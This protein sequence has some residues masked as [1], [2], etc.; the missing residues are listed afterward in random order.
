MYEVTYSFNERFVDISW[1]KMSQLTVSTN[2]VCLVNIPWDITTEVLSRLPVK[3]LMRFKCVS[4]S[5]YDLISNDT[6]FQKKHLYHRSSLKILVPQRET[7][8]V[9]A[10]SC[11][12]SSLN[13]GDNMIHELQ[14][15]IGIGGPMYTNGRFHTSCDGLFCIRV[16]GGGVIIWNP[17]TRQVRECPG[18]DLVVHSLNP[19][20]VVYSLAHDSRSDVYKLL[21][22]FKCSHFHPYRLCFYSS[23]MATWRDVE[24]SSCDYVRYDVNPTIVNGAF[25]WL[26]CHDEHFKT[27]DVVV[28]LDISD[29]TYG[30]FAMPRT[31][32]DAK[33]YPMLCALKGKL[34]LFTSQDTSSLNYEIWVMNEYGVVDSMS[35]MASIS[36]SKPPR[37][38]YGP[39]PYCRPLHM[40]EDGTIVIFRCGK[41]SLY[42]DGRFLCDTSVGASCDFALSHLYLESLIS[43]HII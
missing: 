43:P 14:L 12:T 21:G 38:F 34:C 11:S 37:N 8:G 33:N 10:Y 26:G 29:E 41:T 18:F 1:K 39:D 4:K 7:R 16:Y 42:K 40:L 30:T 31:L 3:S 28:S 20:W 36:F 35:R 13:P 2:Q 32:C 15:P 19:C 23:E 5:F 17:S 6:I 9:I 22:V 27:L 24:N 25:H